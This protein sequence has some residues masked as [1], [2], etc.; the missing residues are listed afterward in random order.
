MGLTVNRGKKKKK[1][2]RGTYIADIYAGD[3][4][5]TEIPH[6][7]DH[8]VDD[9]ARVGLGAERHLQPVHPAFGVLAC[10]TLWRV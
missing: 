4:A 3:T 9:L 7:F 10:G 5:P 8:L 1:Q 6:T 2:K